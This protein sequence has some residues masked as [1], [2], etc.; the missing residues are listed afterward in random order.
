[1]QPDLFVV[2]T[3]PEGPPE[4]WIEVRQLL[5][6]VEVISPS[7]ARADRYRKR[8][9]Y[10]EEG[11]GEYWI[12]DAGQRL[13][14]RWRPGDVEPEIVT[15]DLMWLPREGVVPFRLQIGAYFDKVAS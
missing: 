2:P 5:L 9:I 3:R 7:T 11:V 1:V 4:H 8:V 12:V 10:M 13:I 6:L 14:E 15:D